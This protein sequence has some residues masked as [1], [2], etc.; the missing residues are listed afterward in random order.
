MTECTVSIICTS[1]FDGVTLSST[2]TMQV[3]SVVDYMLLRL[4]TPQ[5]I[6]RMVQEVV[7]KKMEEMNS[8]N[9]AD[10]LPVARSIF[11]E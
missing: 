7:S 3:A 2:K 1:V 6:L 4:L 10:I 9:A 8:T 5:Q 11:G